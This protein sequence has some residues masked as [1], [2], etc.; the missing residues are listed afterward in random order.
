MRSTGLRSL[1]NTCSHLSPPLTSEQTM[2]IPPRPR[3]P[4]ATRPRVILLQLP[5][6]TSV[7]GTSVMPCITNV[8]GTSVMTCITVV[9]G[10]SVLGS[11][12]CRRPRVILGTHRG[13]HMA[14]SIHCRRT[15]H[16][17]ERPSVREYFAKKNQA[18][19]RR[20]N[21]RLSIPAKLAAN[22]ANGHYSVVP[23]S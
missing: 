2:E 23:N 7:P 20:Q 14:D 11:N 1:G 19:W 18:E 12:L 13:G 3:T 21:S 16:R 5:P 4:H 6:I 10:T 8:P 9:P 22:N 15:L 17:R